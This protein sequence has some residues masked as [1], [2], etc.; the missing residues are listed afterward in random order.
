MSLLSVEHVSKHRRENNREHAVL[1]EV[2]LQI[3]TGELIAVWGT[4]RSG[5]TT[6]LRIAAGIEQPDSGHVHF[7]GLD[8]ARHAERSLGTGIGYVAKTLRAG[9]EQSVREQVAAALLARGT[10]ADEARERAR[11]ALCAVGAEQSA[12]M[13]VS[14]LSAG[15]A[16]RVALARSLVLSPTLLVIDEPTA[17]VE[18]SERDGILALLRELA[19][20]GTAVLASSGSPEELA[21]FHRVLTLSEGVLRGETGPGLAPVVAL[22]RRG[23]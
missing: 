6:L 20:N 13:R 16:M 23:M 10:P 8:L 3:E 4:R 9:E 1:R 19:G 7:E 17:T 2:T 12:A 5:R 21:G 18:L 15:E 11:A 22:R 14:E